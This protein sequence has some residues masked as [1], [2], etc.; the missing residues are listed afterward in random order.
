MDQTVNASRQLMNP[1]GF[2]W[3][4]ISFGDQSIR[5]PIVVFPGLDEPIL[6]KEALLELGII[7]INYR[8]TSIQESRPKVAAARPKSQ[9]RVNQNPR[10]KQ[11]PRVAR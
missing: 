1:E 4:E 9:A 7:I 5:R 6:S 11:N 2:F 3:A 8:P 10:V